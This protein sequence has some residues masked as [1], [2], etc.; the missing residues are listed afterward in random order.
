MA[1]VLLLACKNLPHGDNCG[2]R[3]VEDK[4]ADGHCH[5]EG[6]GV[7]LVC[8]GVDH[9]DHP[10]DGEDDQGERQPVGED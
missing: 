4:E 7:L 10:E 5:G 6:D 8:H 2:E 3:K 1:I 9:L